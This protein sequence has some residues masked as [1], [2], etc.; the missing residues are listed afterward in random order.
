MFYIYSKKELV[1]KR[2]KSRFFIINMLLAVA[3]GGAS[4]MIGRYKAV[5]S[6]T[7]HEREFIIYLDQKYFSE[8]QLVKELKSKNINKPYIVL[9]QTKIETGN[10]TSAIFKQN[11]NLFGMKKARIRP[12]TSLGIKR[13]HAYYDKWE[14][15]VEDY[16][17]YQ[18]TTGLV[19]AR[20]DQQYYNML[21]QM[22]YAEDPNYILKVKKLAEEL[23]DKF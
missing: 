20:T 16:G 10:F 21:S 2:V 3:I 1:F 11:H 7:E 6:L 19:K 18:A 9:A 22:G 12:T 13:G 5:N 4:Y 8:D 23:K 17:Y 14:S 15:S